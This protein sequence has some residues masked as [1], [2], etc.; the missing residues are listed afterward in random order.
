MAKERTGFLKKTAGGYQAV[1]TYTAP[2]GTRK[3]L[4]KTCRLRSE[5]NEAIPGLIRR[6][7][8]L[9]LGAPPRGD[10][11]MTVGKLIADYL[12]E[13]AR[14]VV[15]RNGV[16]LS[17]VRSKSFVPQSLKP[18]ERELGGR[19]LSELRPSDIEA[20]RD[21]RLTETSRRIVGGAPRKKAEKEMPVEHATVSISTVNKELNQFRACLRWAVREGIIATS[22][23]E[24]LGN[25]IQRTAETVRWRVLSL[26]EEKRFLDALS[27]KKRG[28]LRSLVIAALD[29]GLR[30]GEL[31]Q[32]RWEDWQR[33]EQVLRIRPETTKT[34]KARIVGV[35]PRLKAELEAIWETSPGRESLP[36]FGKH[37]VKKGMQGASADA[38]LDVV[39]FTDLRHTAISRMVAMDVPHAEIMKISGHEVQATFLRYVNPTEDR[40][41]AAA[42]KLAQFAEE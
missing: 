31:Q 41:R 33:D 16:K 36:I 1:V 34:G 20:Y 18:V 4:K 24:K 7:D 21:R 37:E 3:Y 15:V 32:L 22:P 28:P 25:V 14:P 9:Q 17:G 29:T 39:W 35:T 30:R 6:A 23:F 27:V 42:A 13:K 5:A 10:A 11:S 38:G 2:D 40:A 12:D 8:E 19:R 26:D